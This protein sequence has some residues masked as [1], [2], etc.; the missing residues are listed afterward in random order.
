MVVLQ[1]TKIGGFSWSSVEGEGVSVL[2][3]AAET[4]RRTI[5]PIKASV[6]IHGSE[7]ASLDRKSDDAFEVRLDARLSSAEETS[8]LGIRVGDFVAFDPRFER[9]PAGFIRSRHLDDKAG[10]AAILGAIHGMVKG[11]QAPAQRTTFLFSNYE[12]VGHGAGT[13]FPSDL[14]ELLTVDMAAVGSGQQSDEFSVGVCVKDSGGPYHPEMRRRI[15]QL[16]EAA[17]IPYSLDIYP[18][19]RSDGEAYLV[20][21]GGVKVG[22]LGPGVD[23]SHA[24]ERTHEESVI[25]AARLLAEYIS[26][27]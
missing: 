13:G 18:Y 24:Y 1:L 3:N 6:H 20:A 10:V 8:A 5:L 14:D 9:G 11:G 7:V 15:V 25:H 2:T 4:I 23:A 26:Q 16:A 19:Y 22:L 27:S 21:G 12:D 17:D